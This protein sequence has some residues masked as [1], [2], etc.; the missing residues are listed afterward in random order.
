MKY[1]T[2]I[3]NKSATKKVQAE[4]DA[5]DQEWSKQ[6]SSQG[7]FGQQG[8][9]VQEENKMDVASKVAITHIKRGHQAWD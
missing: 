2:Q 8:G 3:M 7:G 5:F 9:Q 1:S 6:G 4:L